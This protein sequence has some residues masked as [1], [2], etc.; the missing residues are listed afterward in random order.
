MDAVWIGIEEPDLFT[1]LSAP[2]AHNGLPL[3]AT[4]A[5]ARYLSIMSV[6]ILKLH[7]IQSNILVGL[8]E[9][10]RGRV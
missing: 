2:V 4:K 10:L 3:C 7:T 9:E 8:S 5:D 6:Q 1:S